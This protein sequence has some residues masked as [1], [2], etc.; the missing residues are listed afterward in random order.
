MNTKKER[1]IW[2]DYLKFLCLCCLI[3]AH[4]SNNVLVLQIRTFDV[5]LLV[6]LSAILASN[7]EILNNFQYYKKRFLRLVIPTWIFITIYLI[8]NYFVNFQDYSSTNILRSYLLQDNS[9]GYVWI[10]YV[11]LICAIVTPFIKNYSYKN[12]YILSG[13]LLILYVIFYNCFDNYYFMIF[14]LYPIIYSL[15][16]FVGINYEKLKKSYR[17]IFIAT[18]LTV[19]L[20]LFIRYYIL[21]GDFA[22]LNKFKYPPK[23][24]YISYTLGISFLL[25]EIFKKIKFKYNRI[26][27]F[28]SKNSLWIYLW[29]ILSIQIVS[30][31]MIENNVLKFIFVFVITIIIVF[32][33]QMII[34]F[35]EKRGLT[36]K[37]TQ[38]FK[39]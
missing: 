25:I 18:C 36:K 6:I 33:Q 17:I 29:H 5:N 19:F 26:I 22:L 31:M 8:I 1:I 9:I 20:T 14:I 37:I 15:I 3:I 10:I 34:L 28:V 11:Y 30:K 7:S 21:N 27:S 13:I 35:L 39:G 32:I 4:T 12:K 16:T 38:Y 24:Y 2:I 23:I